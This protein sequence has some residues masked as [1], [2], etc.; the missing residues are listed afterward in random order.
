MQLTFV[1]SGRKSVFSDIWIQLTVQRL[2]NV[3]HCRSSK[4]NRQG[5]MWKFLVSDEPD[6]QGVKGF[7]TE[8]GSEISPR[9]NFG[10]A[11]WK[12]LHFL[13]CLPTEVKWQSVHTFRTDFTD[14]LT[15]HRLSLLSGFTFFSFFSNF[16]FQNLFPLQLFLV[17][18]SY[19]LLFP[20]I[21]LFWWIILI[22][23]VFCFFHFFVFHK[24]LV[25]MRYRLNWQ[26]LSCQFS[27]ANSVSYRIV[28]YY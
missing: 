16:S 5:K 20:I 19:L 21:S 15:V 4:A 25:L 24:L 17:P 10:I 22:I 27:S 1:L 6:D 28:L 3:S 18:H 2:G 12:S 26:V 8:W 11:M 13:Q 14:Y 23:V 7:V 9:E